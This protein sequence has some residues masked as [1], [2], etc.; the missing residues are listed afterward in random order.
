MTTTL[1]DF[2]SAHSVIETTID[3]RRK[4]VS[5]TFKTFVQVLEESELETEKR[6]LPTM[7]SF[8]EAT[9]DELS[10]W[11]ESFRRWLGSLS[12]AE[13]DWLDRQI[14]TWE[15]DKPTTAEVVHRMT[16]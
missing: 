14:V 4:F 1:H 9:A 8:D 13:R 16:L 10:A 12:E 15:S 11:W 7:A 3:Q 6:N 5:A 2:L